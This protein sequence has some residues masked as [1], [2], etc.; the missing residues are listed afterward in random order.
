[1]KTGILITARLGS[2]RLKWKHLL[3]INDQEIIVY[4]IKRIQNAFK[5]EISEGLVEIIIS[6]SLEAENLAFND[7]SDVVVFSG[8][9]NNIPLR[10]LQT[11]QKHNLDYLI[12]IDGDDILCSVIGMREVYAALISG[13]QYI[14][15]KDLPFGMNSMG[16]SRVFLE[17]SLSNHMNDLL[18]TGWGRIFDNKSVREISLPLPL[19]NNKLRF[20]LDYQDDFMFFQAV[21]NHFGNLI[22]DVSDEELVYQVIKYE[23]Y[24]YNESIADEYW[25]NFDSNM[26]KEVKTNES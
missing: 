11:A 6:T 26:Q 22:I 1:M 3:R 7:L 4:L 9:V 24:K 2:T 20:T 21:I 16:Y 18:E 8:S 17:E 25:I 19:N 5:K 12:S 14:K 15:T 23:L 13:V 10:H